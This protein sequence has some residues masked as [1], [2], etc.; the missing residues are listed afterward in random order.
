MEWCRPQADVSQVSSV[1]I[2]RLCFHPLAKHPGPLLARLSACAN[3]YHAK[4]GDRHEWI[5]SLHAQY[6]S[7]VRFTPNSISF[8][9]VSAMDQIF[10]SRQA[11]AIKSDWYEC[12]RGSA[13]GFESTLTARQKARHAVKRR[14]LSHA[15]SERAMKDYEPRIC[16]LVSTWLDCLEAEAKGRDIMDLGEWCN[17]LI[18]DILGDLAFG[19]SFG[20]MTTASERFVTGLIPK[21]TGGWYSLGYHPLTKSLRY[22]IFNTRLGQWI[23][24]QSFRD[25]VRFRDFCIG[26]LNRRKA[27]SPGKDETPGKTDMFEHLLNGRDPET[28][29]GYPMGDL[30][31]ESVLLMVAG[32]QSTSGGLAATLFYLA[33]HPEKLSKLRAEIRTTFTTESAIR[34]D[35]GSALMTLPYLRACIDESLRLSPPTPGHLPREIVGNNGMDIDGDWFPATTNVGVAP[36]AIHRNALY[37]PEPLEFRPERWL[38]ERDKET[39]DDLQLAFVPFSAGATGC[40]GRQLAMMELCLAVARLLWRFD[41]QVALPSRNGPVEYRI[42]DCFV[43][44]GDGP[45]L[46]LIRSPGSGF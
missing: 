40:I 5:Q 31:C 21:T 11:G 26:K 28:G 36:Y 19:D 1:L 13:G 29:Q 22:L 34:Y 8:N 27:Q 44:D 24:G 4:K 2:Y 14:L 42:R 41:L 7:A 45:F 33:H 16:K 37:F 46:R 17:Y 18:F 6:G 23:G 3:W 10:R 32:S 43:G 15:F 39:R 30:A 9:T 38:G 12:I 35:G 25:N 20:L